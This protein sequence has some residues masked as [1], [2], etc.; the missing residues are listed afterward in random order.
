MV[1]DTIA[2]PIEPGRRIN[3]IVMNLFNFGKYNFFLCLVVIL[4]A[5]I[6]SFP[7]SATA[8]TGSGVSPGEELRITVGSNQNLDNLFIDSVPVEVNDWPAEWYPIS[9]VYE[10]GFIFSAKQDLIEPLSL[11]YHIAAPIGHNK[12]IFYRFSK[13][14][15]WI[16]LATTVIDEL[17][18]S[19]GINWSQA[20][21]V[22]L[23]KSE[24]LHIGE[25]S[26]YAY[27]NCDCA[28]SPD[29]PKGTKLLVEDLDSG[30]SVVVT[31][32]DYGPDRAIFP[33]R[34]IDLD[35]VAFR[36]LAS[37][38]FG[39]LKRVMVSEVK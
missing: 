36:Q 10:F 23:A 22:A 18:F 20:Y 31:V 8:S 38:S 32:N 39:L 24:T 27:K 1:Y 28:A 17:D 9:P 12:A 29:Y 7:S 37:P 34:I 14:E 11:N 2:L 16:E 25:A 13:N 19:A 3:Y 26:W 15:A 30:K 33:K 4:V 6:F 21:V 5:L 35:K